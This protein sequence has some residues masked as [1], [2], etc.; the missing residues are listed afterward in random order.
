MKKEEEYFYVCEECGLVYR[1]RIW[2]EKCKL[3]CSRHHACLPEII[4]HA[5]QM[6]AQ[7]P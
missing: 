2:A 1:E 3:F 5:V 7:N 4:R 6:N